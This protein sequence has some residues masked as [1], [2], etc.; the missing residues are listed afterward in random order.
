MNNV[1]NLDNLNNVYNIDVDNSDTLDYVVNLDEMDNIGQLKRQ[2]WV[3]NKTILD[4][5]FENFWDFSRISK[6][7]L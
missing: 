4:K 2:L 3:L 5:Q 1:D 7:F 6:D